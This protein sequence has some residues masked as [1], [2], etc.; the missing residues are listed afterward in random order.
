MAKGQVI[1]RVADSICVVPCLTQISLSIA[2][3]P[4]EPRYSFE[5]FPVW[6]SRKPH[7]SIRLNMQEGC[8]KNNA[9][10]VNYLEK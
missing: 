6:H 9:E 8:L 4:A 10:T 5:S 1:L 3:I 2:L 7:Q